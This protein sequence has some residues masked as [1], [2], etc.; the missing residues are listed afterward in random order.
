MTY[1]SVKAEERLAATSA[2]LTRYKEFANKLKKTSVVV[3]GEFDEIADRHA[4][5][6]LELAARKKII[7]QANSDLELSRKQMVELRAERDRV[8]KFIESWNTPSILNM[9]SSCKKKR[10]ADKSNL[11]SERKLRILKMKEKAV[12]HRLNW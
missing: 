4:R 2:Q 3:K 5:K 7:Q 8:A 12:R 6:I 11:M 1:E 9:M 10:D